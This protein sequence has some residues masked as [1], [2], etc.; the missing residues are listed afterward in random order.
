M[1]LRTKKK[2]T[3]SVARCLHQEQFQSAKSCSFPFYCYLLESF[4]LDSLLVADISSWV[5]HL[6]S[7]LCLGGSQVLDSKQ[8]VGILLPWSFWASSWSVHLAGCPSLH[9]GM[10]LWINSHPWIATAEWKQPTWEGREGQGERVRIPKRQLFMNWLFPE[11]SHNGPFQ[12]QP[13]NIYS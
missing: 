10:P 12:N 3:D 1:E 4:K 7:P 6:H 11:S 9:Q 2:I 13:K 8:A 5:V